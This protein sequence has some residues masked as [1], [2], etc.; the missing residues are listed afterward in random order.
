MKNIIIFSVLCLFCG[1]S[2]KAQMFYPTN[3]KNVEECIFF[4]ETPL[5]TEIS[6]RAKNTKKWIGLK[7]LNNPKM[8]GMYL[9]QF[10]NQS[11]EKLTVSKEKMQLKNAVTGK[12]KIFERKDLY[13]GKEDKTEYL[14]IK[15]SLDDG[16]IGFS[17]SITQK[18]ITQ[19]FT[20][21]KEDSQNDIYELS[22]D[23]QEGIYILK[24]IENDYE[25]TLPNGT[26]KI[27]L[28]DLRSYE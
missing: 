8:G 16:M 12:V 13:I 18:G 27:Y 28:A 2:V 20:I 19:G 5:G 17:G 7:M 11:K 15:Y 14:H 3:T 22:I 23:G 26:K 9:V 24:R 1:F 6:Y 25:F 4:M 21:S 10:P